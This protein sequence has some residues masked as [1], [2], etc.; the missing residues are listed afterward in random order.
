[1]QEKYRDKPGMTYKQMDGR[2]MEL[3]DANFNAVI[4]KA[5]TWEQEV[6]AVHEADTEYDAARLAWMLYSAEKG[7]RTMRKRS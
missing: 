2:S 4:D 6:V 3:P 5:A 7:R 1:M